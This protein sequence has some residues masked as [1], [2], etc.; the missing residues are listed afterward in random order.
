M[1]SFYHS[2]DVIHE[3]FE[4]LQSNCPN[5][6]VKIE[7]W[8]KDPP[9]Q[10]VHIQKPVAFAGGVRPAAPKR[11]MLLFGEH[12]RELISPETALQFARDLCGQNKD[13]ANVELEKPGM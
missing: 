12:A 3:F 4:K 1:P 13:P 9:L 2:T 7:H 11:T 10:L 8:G 5:A 6:E